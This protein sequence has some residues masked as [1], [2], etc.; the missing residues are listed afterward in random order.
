MPMQGD[1]R[2]NSSS[3]VTT[4]DHI[5]MKATAVEALRDADNAA[6]SFSVIGVDEGQFYPG[7]GRAYAEYV[8]GMGKNCIRMDGR[9]MT[10]CRCC[11]VCGALGE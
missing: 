6:R 1:I 8:V 5:E 2:Y 4:H 7:A 10:A 3:C 11:G 9:C